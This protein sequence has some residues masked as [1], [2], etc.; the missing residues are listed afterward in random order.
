MPKVQKIDGKRVTMCAIKMISKDR[1]E[2]SVHI[3]ASTYLR[4][5]HPIPRPGCAMHIVAVIQF[6]WNWNGKEEEE[7]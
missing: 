1:S 5:P 2:T 3:Y 6:P 7:R 4:I